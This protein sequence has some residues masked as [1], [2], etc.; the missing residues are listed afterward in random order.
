MPTL[1][2]GFELTNT[3]RISTQESQ[4]KDKENVI[5]EDGKPVPKSQQVYEELLGDPKE[6]VEAPKKISAFIDEQGQ[7]IIMLHGFADPSYT[8]FSLTS[9]RP[10]I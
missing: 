1:N 5:D 7:K 4:E 8:P 3:L 6:I 2:V 9:P 10:A